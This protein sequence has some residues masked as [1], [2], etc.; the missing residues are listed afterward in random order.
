MACH[1]NSCDSKLQLADSIKSIM[2]SRMAKGHPLCPHFCAL[3][4]YSLQRSTITAMQ[5]CFLAKFDGFNCPTI[6]TIQF[7]FLSHSIKLIETL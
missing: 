2:C 5:S 1:K 3:Y 7:H 6:R 4:R